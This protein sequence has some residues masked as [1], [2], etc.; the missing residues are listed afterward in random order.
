MLMVSLPARSEDHDLQ[1][2]DEAC[3]EPVV[4]GLPGE[5]RRRAP[6]WA[7]LKGV[8]SPRNTKD[9]YAQRTPSWPVVFISFSAS[10][11]AG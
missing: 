5:P 7:C 9:F 8:E 4:I 11:A 10:A 6:L 3:V 2:R 1:S